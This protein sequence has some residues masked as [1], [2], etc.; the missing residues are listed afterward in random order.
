[1]DCIVGTGM[2]QRQWRLARGAGARAVRLFTNYEAIQISS[3]I[4]DGGNANG[5]YRRAQI[6]R[7]QVL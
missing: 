2:H 7:C 4:L 1:M 3:I 6:F 5:L